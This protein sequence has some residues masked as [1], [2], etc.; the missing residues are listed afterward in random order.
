M[1]GENNGLNILNPMKIPWIWRYPY[2]YVH[3]TEN[4][5]GLFTYEFG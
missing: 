4:L 3:G 1:D 2:F 5:Y